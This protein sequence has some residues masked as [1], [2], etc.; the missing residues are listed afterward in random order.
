MCLEKP[1]TAMP[2]L[3]DAM[4]N[5][6]RQT[7]GEVSW[8]EYGYR[9]E[10]SFSIAHDNRHIFIK[11]YVQEQYVRA[12]CRQSN[13]PVYEDSCVE[14]FI[15]WDNKGYYNIEF[16]CLGTCLMGY[17]ADRHNRQLLD[18]RLIASIQRFSQ[19][20][21]SYTNNADEQGNWYLLVQIPLDIFAHHQFSTLSGK[22][23][24]VNFYKCGDLLPKPHFLSWKKITSPTPDFHRPEYFGKIHFV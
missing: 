12:A 19:I 16:N 8:P 22:E 24:M 9:P 3:K 11:Y 20:G 10:V 23:A 4:D 1:D 6:P 18:A 15:A 17:G 21:Y 13:E 2:L 14:F 5:L 7:I